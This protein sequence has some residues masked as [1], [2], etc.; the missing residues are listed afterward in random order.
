MD[1]SQNI[2]QRISE[3]LKLTKEDKDAI[4]LLLIDYF[5]AMYAGYKQNK[6]FSDS[7]TRVMLEQGGKEEATVFLQKMNYLGGTFGYAELR[8]APPVW[9]FCLKLPGQ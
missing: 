3:L 4:R 5:S 6:A 8:F 7:V 2:S 9:G 1:I